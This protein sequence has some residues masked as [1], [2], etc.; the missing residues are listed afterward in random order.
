M[1]AQSSFLD[2]ILPTFGNQRNAAPTYCSN[3]KMFISDMY[4]SAAGNSYYKGIRFSDRLIMVERIGLY[5]NWTYI[6]EVQIYGFDG[7]KPTLLSSHKFEKE[8][9]NKEL[10]REKANLIMANYISSQNILKTG[11][12]GN[13]NDII[14]NATNLIDETYNNPIENIHRLQDGIQKL[15]KA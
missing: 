15:L 1:K 14:V 11:N 5:H 13:E 12:N 8:F 7:T 4:T 3:Q 9:Y 2:A 10:I 6:D